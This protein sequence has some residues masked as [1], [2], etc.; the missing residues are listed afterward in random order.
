MHCPR[1]QSE[2]I[3]RSKRRGFVE[4]GPFTLVLLRPF[5]CRHCECRFFR[6]PI[7]SNDPSDKPIG[8]ERIHSPSSLPTALP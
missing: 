1:C 3:R 7:N 2:E 6:W 8:P 4:H 5:R